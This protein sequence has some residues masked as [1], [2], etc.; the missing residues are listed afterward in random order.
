MDLH[1]E[2]KLVPIEL[3]SKNI[4]ENLIS[5]YLHDLS[6]FTNDL[7]VNQNGRFEYEGLELYFIKEELKPLFIYL[8]DNIVGFILLNNGKYV[9]Q[10]IDF[11][12]HEFFI[13]KS[14]RRSGIGAKAME[15]LFDKYKGKYRIVQLA[16]NK[17]AI[18]FWK[19]IYKMQGI[20]FIETIE[21]I[22]DVECNIQVLD[23]S[24]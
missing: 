18:N 23:V 21:I 8:K 19:S 17:L 14:Y 12:V 10:D 2:M 24:N 7:K 13:L 3:E 15:G 9:P 5:I 11:S 20:D 22:D 6:E 4:L 16:D 1:N